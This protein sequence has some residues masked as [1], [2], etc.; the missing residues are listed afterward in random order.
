ME[1]NVAIIEDSE[2]IADLVCKFVMDK[3]ACPVK[4]FHTAEEYL[5]SGLPANL[6]LLDYYLDKKDKQAMNGLEFMRTTETERKT[7]PVI[8]ISGLTDENIIR[9]LRNHKIVGFIDK[10]APE[11]WTRLEREIRKFFNTL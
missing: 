5:A 2:I 10:D 8:M 1:K 3:F 7:V 11:F 9:E 4:V 6:I